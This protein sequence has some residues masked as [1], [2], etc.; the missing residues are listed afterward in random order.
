MENRLH[1]IDFGLLARNDR[2]AEF[3]DF[4]ISYGR[5]PAHQDRPGMMWD[6]GLEE[7]PVGDRCLLR[8]KENAISVNALTVAMRMLRV[9]FEYMAPISASSIKTMGAVICGSHRPS[10]ECCKDRRGAG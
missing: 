10:V 4:G 7:L 5:F 2:L 6:H 8:N 1:L 9:L 3:V